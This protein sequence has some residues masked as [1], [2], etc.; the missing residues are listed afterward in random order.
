MADNA[1]RQEEQ[2]KQILKN[3]RRYSLVLFDSRYECDL[4]ETRLKEHTEW[5]TIIKMYWWMSKRD[6]EDNEVLLRE[7]NSYIIV[8]TTDMMGRWV[9]IPNIDMIFFYCALK[10][11]WT[12]VQAVGRCLRVAEGKHAPVIIDWCD[13]PLLNKQMR[14]RVKSYKLEYG[15]DILIQKIK[16]WQAMKEE[17]N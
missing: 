9:D 6:T 11:K 16:I 5:T 8:G 10:F 12:I 17:A 15:K 2:I 4:F 3:H 13:V 1:E 14:E 7:S